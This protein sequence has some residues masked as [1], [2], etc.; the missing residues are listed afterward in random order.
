[1]ALKEY[2]SIVVNSSSPDLWG[3]AGSGTLSATWR[4]LF[5]DSLAGLYS[6]NVPSPP[7]WS[8]TGIW[9]I[10]YPGSEETGRQ[11]RMALFQNGS[12]VIGLWMEQQYSAYLSRVVW[13]QMSTL[14]GTIDQATINFKP[15]SFVLTCRGELQSDDMTGTCTSQRHSGQ[16]SRV[17]FEAT[18]RAH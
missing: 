5:T 14:S 15:N 11:G 10:L 12:Q 2:D 3:T 4:V 1:M 7:S 13:T 16:V 8:V 9:D 18:R 6:V 17:R